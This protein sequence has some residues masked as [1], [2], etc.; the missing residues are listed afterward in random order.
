MNY[1]L[2]N[3]IP[4]ISYVLGKQIYCVPMFLYP[5]TIL[6]QN[7]NIQ[8]QLSFQNYMTPGCIALRDPITV[9]NCKYVFELPQTTLID[10]TFPLIFE[11]FMNFD[12]WFINHILSKI[13]ICMFI[14][15]FLFFK[16]NF[17]LSVHIV[18][19]IVQ[20]TH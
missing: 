6:S 9:K 19:F 13:V 8:E 3:E 7:P 2:E 14:L 15:Y 1:V 11:T 16:Y 4:N 18:V 5:L 10:K 20:H 17:F 12:M